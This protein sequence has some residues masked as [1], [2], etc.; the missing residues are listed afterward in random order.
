LPALLASPVKKKH[1][2]QIPDEGPGTG[3]EG[4]S[5]SIFSNYSIFYLIRLELT[6]FLFIFR[7]CLTISSPLF[8]LSTVPTIGDGPTG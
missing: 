5:F 8:R 6:T 7:S 1:I 3:E 2:C 4:C